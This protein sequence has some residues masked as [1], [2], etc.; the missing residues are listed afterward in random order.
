MCRTVISEMMFSV[1]FVASRREVK[2]ANFS[3]VVLVRPE[4]SALLEHTAAPG[5]ATRTSTHR[6]FFAALG[7]R[8]K[9]DVM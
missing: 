2:V 6:E 8:L 3:G 7:T 4:Q 5:S 9:H 1:L